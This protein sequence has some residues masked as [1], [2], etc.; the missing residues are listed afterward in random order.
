MCL[1]N[2]HCGNV[3]KR[4]VEGGQWRCY[5]A[6]RP[7]CPSNLCPVLPWLVGALINCAKGIRKCCS[8]VIL[9]PISC[10]ILWRHF[11]WRYCATMLHRCHFVRASPYCPFHGHLS[12]SVSNGSIHPLSASSASDAAQILFGPC[13][14]EPSAL[15]GF[16]NRARPPPCCSTQHALDRL[17]G[18]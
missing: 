3:S 14:H 18:A 12:P 13:L 6:L 5:S 7:L 11:V 9:S 2:V 15:V 10:A 1:A 4:G 8:G 16:L 17:W